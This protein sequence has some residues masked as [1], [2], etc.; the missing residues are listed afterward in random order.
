MYVDASACTRTQ[1]KCAD[2][3]RKEADGA[4]AVEYVSS[5]GGLTSAV[6]IVRFSPTGALL[7]TLKI[8][9]ACQSRAAGSAAEQG[10]SFSTAIANPAYP[11]ARL[12]HALHAP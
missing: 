5:V 4:P 7:D 6:N 3:V 8:T 10:T 2:E 9:L 11:S 1:Q 12:T